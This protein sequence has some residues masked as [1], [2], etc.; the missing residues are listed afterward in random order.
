M[1]KLLGITVV[2][3]LLISPAFSF[4][5]LLQE[6]MYHLQALPERALSLSARNLQMLQ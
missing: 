5:I 3:A 6:G 1:K 2:F 4:F